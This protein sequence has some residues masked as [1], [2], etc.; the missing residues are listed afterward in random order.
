[1]MSYL[2]F[3]NEF[4]FVKNNITS[5][6]HRLLF[7]EELYEGGTHLSVSTLSAYITILFI[8]M[9]FTNIII[10]YVCI[11]YIYT[12]LPL[13]KRFL[14]CRFGHWIYITGFVLVNIHHSHVV[15]I[16]GIQI[17]VIDDISSLFLF[18]SDNIQNNIVEM[19]VHAMWHLLLDLW[20]ATLSK[21]TGVEMHSFR[22]HI[23]DHFDLEWKSTLKIVEYTLKIVEY[24]LKIV[25][26]TLKR[27]IQTITLEWIPL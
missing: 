9:A 4:D 18:L 3:F 7:P 8:W 27:V 19:H 15:K 17:Q 6:K 12:W 1:M 21:Y 5:V 13:G 11:Y 14:F 23:R 26:S 22:S 25:E 10:P 16:P 20:H 24:T 2:S